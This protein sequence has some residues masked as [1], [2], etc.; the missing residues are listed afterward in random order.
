MTALICFVWA[1]GFP[2]NSGL[3]QV[4]RFSVLDHDLTE[5]AGEMTPTLKVR[6][7]AVYEHYADR[8]AELYE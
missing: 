6:R 7:P 2:R 1:I 5:A 4:K 8:F 3:E